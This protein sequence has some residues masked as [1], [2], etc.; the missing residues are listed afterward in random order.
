M[1][2]A[3]PQEYVTIWLTMFCAPRNHT[4]D[5]CLQICSSRVCLHHLHERFQNRCGVRSCED[6][7]CSTCVLGQPCAGIQKKVKIRMPALHL[8]HQCLHVQVT[9]VPVRGAIRTVSSRSLSF[10][11]AKSKTKTVSIKA[12]P[13]SL[14]TVALCSVCSFQ[15]AR[16]SPRWNCTSCIQC[17]LKV[18]Y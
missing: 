4:H 3:F 9:I 17:W 7:S 1:I 11:K 6:F 13:P 5:T 2:S 10:S 12:A 18:V 14:S 15:E 16:D 8:L